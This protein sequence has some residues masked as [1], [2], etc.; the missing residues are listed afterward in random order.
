[1]YINTF[2]CR[3]GRGRAGPAVLT[4]ME[5]I[6]RNPHRSSQ[7][8][9]AIRRFFGSLYLNDGHRQRMENLKTR[10]GC[11]KGRDAAAYYAAMYLLTANK[12]LY[13]HA[14]NCFCRCGIEFGYVTRRDMSPHDYTLFSAARDIYTDEP[15]LT[16][17][18]LANSMVV[19]PLAFSLIINALL[20]ARYGS[21]VLDGP[22][23]GNST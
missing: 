8:G 10:L 13:H 7:P 2:Q 19:D 1:M 9:T 18:D 3:A 17:A 21:A 4:L 12:S 5:T 22:E 20:A 11:R 15:G 23:R 6:P 14:A 16:L